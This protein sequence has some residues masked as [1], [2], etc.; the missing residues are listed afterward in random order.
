MTA[1]FLDWLFRCGR[2]GKSLGDYMECSL[3][4]SL[5][6]FGKR[7]TR[8]QTML[9]AWIESG[10]GCVHILFYFILFYIYIYIYIYIYV[11]VCVCVWCVYIYNKYAHN[12]LRFQ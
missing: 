12:P 7:A 8:E 2:F 6:V 1:P 4:V 11:C 10:E 3:C 5:A 9:I